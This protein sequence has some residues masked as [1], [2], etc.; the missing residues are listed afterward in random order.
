RVVVVEADPIKALEAYYEGFE[1]TDMLKAASLGDVFITATGNIN[2]IRREHLERMKDGAILANSGHFNVEISLKDLGELAVSRRRIS[3][4]VDEF[5]LRDGRRL[6]LL[7][8]GRLVNLVAA[9]GHPSEV[10]DLSFGNQVLAVMLLHRRG[11]AMPRKV[12]KL[13]RS[14]DRR[15]ARLKLMSLGVMIEKLTPEQVKYL[16]SWSI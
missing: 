3:D 4:Y 14:L 12:L 9:E 13:P 16:S 6:Y 10:M 7:A 5:T 8:E 1:V 15:V 2:V 11:G